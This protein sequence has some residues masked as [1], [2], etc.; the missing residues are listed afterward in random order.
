[1]SLHGIVPS[2]STT[3]IRCI[4]SKKEKEVG[5]KKGNEKKDKLEFFLIMKIFQMYAVS[6]S[7]DISSS[8]IGISLSPTKL[9]S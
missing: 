2:L 6:E 9:R 8:D 1:M 4:K 7:I 5:G 3:T